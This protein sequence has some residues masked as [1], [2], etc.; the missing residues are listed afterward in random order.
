MAVYESKNPTK[1][2]R[3]YFFRIKYKDIFG[4]THDYTS[5]KFKNKKDAINEEA[6]YRIKLSEN[7]TKTFNITIDDAFNE[8]ILDKEKKVKKQTIIKIKNMYRHLSCIKDTRINDLNI[9]K[10]KKLVTYLENTGFC[11]MFLNKIL[12]LFKSIINYSNKYYNTSNYILKFVENFNN[13][14]EFQKEMKFYTYDEYIKFSKVINDS[15]WKLFF[16]LLYF[17][18][19]RCGECQALQF[20]DI[21]FNK[22]T[23]SI[24]KTLTSKIKGEN[25]TI[26]TP[27]TKNSIRVLPLSEKLLEGL[28]I[29]FNE[30][31]KFKDYSDT[32]FIFGN[33]I[34]F[35]ENTIQLRKNKYCDL[36]ELPR[37]RIHDFRHSCT[38]FLVNYCH[39]SISL[40][41]KY[42]GHS[43]ITITLN[44]YTHMYESE[45]NNI[46][47]VLNNL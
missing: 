29:R 6:L 21:D 38:S 17:L 10:Y 36:A 45:L 28:K 22:K 8:F 37:I 40:V 9:T 3:K 15:E 44:T 41:S 7:K 46:T 34:P 30:A 25:W 43:N 24:N 5:P 11:P 23:I 27:K 1:D 4:E 32:W 35:K 13:K 47:N 14:N 33:S 19:L 18:G 12:G 39:A 42:L 2:G 31:N 20:K 26:S 16:D